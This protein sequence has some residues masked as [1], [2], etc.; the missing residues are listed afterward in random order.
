MRILAPAHDD[1]GKRFERER[2][3]RNPASAQTAGEHRFA[4]AYLKFSGLE[5]ERR[6]K[7]NKP[8]RAKRQIATHTHCSNLMVKNVRQQPLVHPEPPAFQIYITAVF[9]FCEIHISDAPL[10]AWWWLHAMRFPEVGCTRPSGKR[11]FRLARSERSC[12]NRA[13]CNAGWGRT[14][15]LS[16]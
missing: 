4:A 10:D 2:F 15:I 9:Q 13:W 16:I 8:G 6:P 12:S 7:N 3:L 5:K 14:A 1:Q 11:T